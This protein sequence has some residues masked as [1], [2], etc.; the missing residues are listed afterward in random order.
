MS[1]LIKACASVAAMVIAT[2]EPS[3]AAVTAL[4]E[5]DSSTMFNGSSKR[6]NPVD[7]LDTRGTIDW[8]F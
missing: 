5:Y 2:V 7:E 6:Y 4:K 3:L 8:A 1:F